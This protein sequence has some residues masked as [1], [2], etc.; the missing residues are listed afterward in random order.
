[1]TDLPLNRITLVTL[2][3][4][5]LGR[6][7]AFYAA[8]GW[9][10][11]Q[12]VD[13]VSF[14]QMDRSVMALFDLASLAA[15]QGRPGTDLGAGAATYAQNFEDRASVDEEWEAALDAGAEPLK[16][17]DA[18]LWGGYSGYFADPDGHVWEI[19]HN[20][21]WPMDALGGTWIPE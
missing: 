12:A 13:G 14:Y 5:D 18:T 2:G 15:D 4:A 3:V 9:E 11:T 1:M 6:S 8:L 20:P 16:A 10:E 21:L 19:A 17:P 7:R